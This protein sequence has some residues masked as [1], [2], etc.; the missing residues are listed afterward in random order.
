MGS[1]APILPPAVVGILG[2]GQLGRMLGSAA[3]A[4]GY[5]VAILDPDPSCPAAAIADRHVVADYDDT[6]AALELAAG[7]A[8]VTY[9]LEH[10][11]ALLVDALDEQL[12]VRPGSFALKTTQ[13]RLAERRFL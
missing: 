3:R 7:C 2:G 8:V 5:R 9:E 10:V 13:H 6:T 11:S 4:L 1:E 12:P